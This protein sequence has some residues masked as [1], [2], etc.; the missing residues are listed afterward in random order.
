LKCE[1]PNSES[2]K[3]Q[4]LKERKK[5]LCQK[6]KTSG[7]F[8]QMSKKHPHF[9]KIRNKYDTI[10]IRGVSQKKKDTILYTITHN[11]AIENGKL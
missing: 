9:R 11:T 5:Y 8:S 7:K 6:R 4:I 10:I 3:R 1:T 2:H